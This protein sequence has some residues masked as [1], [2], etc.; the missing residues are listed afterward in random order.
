[1]GL[2]QTL[3]DAV[4]KIFTDKWE[5]IDGKVV[6]HE[7][8]L[9][10]G[11]HGS[12]VT[13]TVLY[14]D[15]ADSTKLVDGYKDWFAAEMYKAFLTCAGRLITSEGGQIVSYDGDRVMAVYMG[16]FPNT[17]AVKTAQKLNWAVKNIIE[18]AR[19]AKYPANQ[20]VMKHVV[21]VDSSKLLAAIAGVRGN[22]DIVWVGRA[23]NY[24]AKLCA[25]DDAFATWITG[26]VYNAMTD[27]VKLSGGKGANLWEERVWKAMNNHQIYRSNSTWSLS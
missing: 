11:N 7:G 20:Y 21:G 23:A 24:A 15:L 27:E 17:R 19:K 13:A 16:D 1:M 3:T 25:L 14:A 12:R 8:I 2:K 22:N 4:G 18:P 9:K 10:V 26:T 5:T 6:P